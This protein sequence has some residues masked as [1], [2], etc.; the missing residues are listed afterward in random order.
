M[1]GGRIKHT[2]GKKKKKAA[3]P[4]PALG[5]ITES[6]NQLE[7]GTTIPLP[8]TTTTGSHQKAISQEKGK[9]RQLEGDD[10]NQEAP[11]ADHLTLIESRSSDEI[12]SNKTCEALAG[13]EQATGREDNHSNSSSTVE[14]AEDP[15]QHLLD[16]YESSSAVGWGGVLEDRELTINKIAEASFAEVYRLSDTLGDTSIVKVMRLTTDEDPTLSEWK[17]TLPFEDMLSEIRIMEAIGEL[18]GMLVF[19]SALL[20]R[21]KASPSLIKA[22]DDY[23]AV[24]DY[25]EHPHPKDYTDNSWFLVI[26]L[27]DAGD[28]LEDLQINDITQMWDV[29]IGVVVALA[30]A[31]MEFEFEVFLPLFI[32]LYLANFSIASRFTREQRLLHYRCSS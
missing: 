8:P 25:S 31:E 26:E 4:R 28:V 6:L 22:S 14:T 19:R 21:G 7:I 27:G 17:A 30:R 5:D 3:A 10:E 15:L 16:D 18:H 32:L 29:T 1:A 11:A 12:V 24:R 20:V 2:Y 13:D 23:F 9:A